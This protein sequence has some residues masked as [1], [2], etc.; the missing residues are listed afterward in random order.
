MNN[1]TNNE[2]LSQGTNGQ[3]DEYSAYRDE[4]YERMRIEMEK[5]RAERRAR[6]HRRVMKNR[7][8]AIAILLVIIF[9]IV[10]ACSGKSDNKPAADSSSQ[11][12]ST[13][14]AEAKTTSKK[15]TS[16]NSKA[17]ETKHKIEQSN[18]MTFVDGILIV[19]KTYS[20]P[21]D[22]A[23]GV[24][25]IAQNAFD[26]MAAAAAQDGITLF[27]NS[28]YRS[29]Q[30]QESLYNSYAAER[31]TEAADEVSSRPGHSEHQT[32]L[33]FDVN[34]TEDSF[35]GTPEANWLAEHCAE[36]GFIIRYPEGKEDKTGYVYEPWHIRYL[37]KEKA[38]AVTKSG[39]CLEEYLGVTSDYK[40]AEDQNCSS[41]N[42]SDT[43]SSKADGY[44]DGY[45][46]DNTNYDYQY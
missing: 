17:E 37:G 1:Q 42:T 19:N 34:T 10:K 26:E 5:R 12:E 23:P 38:Q 22:Y 29:Y 11:T 24:S 40:Y 7:I 2:N 31:G 27:V 39:L 21:S 9:V 33:T 32:G 16:D 20:L 14:Q 6:E 28:S 43:Q 41:L 35:A 18:G 25:T 44:T 30:D 3:P 8:I 46:Q 4:E 13:K 36:Y 15:K 45:Y